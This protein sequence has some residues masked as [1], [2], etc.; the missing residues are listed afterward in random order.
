MV[1]VSQNG[2][3]WKG[4]LQV[5]WSNSSA[6]TGPTG[7]GCPGQ[8]PDSFWMSPRREI[9]LAGAFSSGLQACCIWIPLFPFPWVGESHVGRQHIA[10]HAIQLFWKTVLCEG[11]K[12]GRREGG[13][14]EVRN[15]FITTRA[16]GSLREEEALV[17][18]THHSL[19]TPLTVYQLPGLISIPC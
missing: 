15:C 17:E 16:G 6:Q 18:S 3:G 2:R 12:D 9:P 5:I 14:E 7:A 8:C 13:T 1:S 11:G 10:M 19:I 4:P